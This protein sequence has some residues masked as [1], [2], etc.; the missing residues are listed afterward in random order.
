MDIG[1]GINIILEHL[2][3]QQ[4]KVLSQVD[5]VHIFLVDFLKELQV[6]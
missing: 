3:K 1:T 5:L 6:Q 4:L 2:I